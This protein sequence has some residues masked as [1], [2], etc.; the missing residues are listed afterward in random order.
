MTDPLGESQVIP[1]LAG[2]SQKGYRLFLLSFEKPNRFA[3]GKNRMEE[4][5]SQNNITWFPLTYTASPAVIGTLSDI[6]RA[7]KTARRI[8]EKEEIGLVHCR[9]YIAAL[10]GQYLYKKMNIPYVFDMRGFWADE[11]VEGGIWNRKNPLFRWIYNYFKKKEKQFLQEAAHIISLT[12]AGRQEILRMGTDG[13]HADNISVI[14]CCA[15]AKLFRPLLPDTAQSR[16]LRELNI[17]RQNLV[18]SYLGSFGTWYMAREMFD[19]F[20]C[21]QEQHP[22]AIFL[23][24][25]QDD[26]AEITELAESRGVHRNSLRIRSAQRNEVPA[27]LALSKAM[28]FFILPAFS[29]KA[30]SPVK[31]GEALCMG[32]PVICNDGIGDCTEILQASGAGIIIKD[33]TEKSYAEALGKIS[34]LTERDAESIRTHALRYFDLQAGTEQYAMVYRNILKPEQPRNDNQK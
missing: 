32:I 17:G 24:I 14:P 30:S 8:A 5:L 19:F 12:K 18:I 33:F 4:I 11:R 21:L 13:V 22:D 31:M 1:Y 29:K 15:D 3:A 34:A 26:A 25:T 2:L 28:L 10:V 23:I 27:L 9:S 20:R 16:L 7:K 6:R